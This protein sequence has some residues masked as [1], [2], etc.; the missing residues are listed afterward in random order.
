MEDV[1]VKSCWNVT[2]W[3]VALFAGTVML[4]HVLT[5]DLQPEAVAGGP[6]EALAAAK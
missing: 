5:A 1:N 2:F 3:A 4:G 6:V